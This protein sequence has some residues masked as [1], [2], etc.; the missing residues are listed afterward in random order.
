ML[1]ILC[2]RSER[3]DKKNSLGGR[4]HIFHCL[5]SKQKLVSTPTGSHIFTAIMKQAAAISLR[6]D[7]V[8][9][10]C[11]IIRKTLFIAPLFL[12]VNAINGLN[13]AY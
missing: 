12:N 4:P 10:P 13:D 6:F 5:T 1:S 11:K 3:I 9:R 8:I 2:D 7:L